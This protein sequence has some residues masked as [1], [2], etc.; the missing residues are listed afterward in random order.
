MAVYQ[1]FPPGVLLRSLVQDFGD[2]GGKVDS[3]GA[4]DFIQDRE[5]WELEGKDGEYN[6]CLFL[7]FLFNRG[8][9]AFYQLR[10]GT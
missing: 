3:F 8:H 4:A 1:S 10:F 6:L 5:H 9:S 2:V 7:R